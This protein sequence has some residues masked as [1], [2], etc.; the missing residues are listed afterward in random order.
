MKIGRAGKSREN[1]EGET[2]WRQAAPESKRM[3]S[4]KL[5]EH[6]RMLKERHTKAYLV[7]CD[8]EIVYERYADDWSADKVHYTASAAKG[9]VGGL[10]L[11][12]AIDDGLIGIDDP[13]CKYV[14][15]WRDDP[16]KSRITI[17]QLASHTSGLDDANEDGVPHKDL[18]GWKGEF[19]R[20]EPDPFLISRDVTPVVFAPGTGY[21]YSNPGIAMMS[22]AV[23]VSLKG[24]AH[25]D[26][27]TQLWERIAKPLGL[28]EDE[29]QIGYGKTFELDGLKLVGT[30]GGG[31]LTARA[32]AK[33]GR[34]LLYEGRWEGKQLISANVVREAL[35]HS[36]T[37]STHSFGFWV[38]SDLAGNKIWPPLPSDT[39]MALG[40]GNQILLVCPSR[41]LVAVRN[42]QDMD[43]DMPRSMHD[44]KFDQYIGEPLMAAFEDAAPYSKNADGRN[45]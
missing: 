16:V 28:T 15:Q 29:W 42:G 36:G 22:Y 32:M 1:H 8:D 12:L 7:V 2:Q 25:E 20:Q 44:K 37:P 6:W 24:T 10:S 11:M 30:W 43:P 35:K 19:W 33:I 5:D 40:A 27:R 39:V 38:N 13:A 23:T 21:L 45:E 18:P 14:P 4:G 31:A 17:R 3:K 9:I 26:I 41:K 34:L